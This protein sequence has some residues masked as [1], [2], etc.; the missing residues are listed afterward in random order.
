MQEKL[1][2]QAW[3]GGQ[4]S[5]GLGIQVPLDGSGQN[6][7]TG[8]LELLARDRW[9]VGLQTML[10]ATPD[11][12]TEE[13]WVPAN[14]LRLSRRHRIGTGEITGAIDWGLGLT[15]QWFPSKPTNKLLPTAHIRGTAGNISVR[16]EMLW[17]TQPQWLVS[18]EVHIPG[19]VQV[20]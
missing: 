16:G 4:L 2:P 9:I 13:Q 20:F 12:I 6:L 8:Q 7:L 5:F 3:W 19:I 1:D 15:H 18:V 17:L 11:G 14:A 10:Q